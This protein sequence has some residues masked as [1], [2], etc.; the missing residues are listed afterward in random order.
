MSEAGTFAYSA[1][2]G[3]LLA[4]SHSLAITLGP[5]VRVNCISPGWINVDD[6]AKTRRKIMRSIPPGASARLRTSPPPSPFS[7]RRRQV[8]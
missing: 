8:S 5:D 6:N 3:G 4:L 2:K 7:F 1:S